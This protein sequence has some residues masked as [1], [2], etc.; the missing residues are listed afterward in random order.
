M[1]VLIFWIVGSFLVGVLASSRK[2]S[3]VGAFFAS[4]ILSP[5][6]IGLYVLALGRAG[7]VCPS[8]R[9]KIDL[10]ATICPHCRTPRVGM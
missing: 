1:E 8:C 10:E 9:E 6:I 4:L 5:L 2:R 7:A 3:G